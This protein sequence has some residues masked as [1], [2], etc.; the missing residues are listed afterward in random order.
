MDEKQFTALMRR[1]DI[2]T[3]LLV[4][5]IIK[6]NPVIIQVDILTKIG[7]K[8]SEIADILG[9][10]EN[11]IYVTQNKLRKANKKGALIGKNS[12]ENEV[13]TNAE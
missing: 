8:T 9:K 4:Y 5:S 3:K 7:L 1:F 13:N 12:S 2:L 11:Q 6:D 10:T